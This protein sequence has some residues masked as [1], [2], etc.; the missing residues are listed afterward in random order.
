[1]PDDRFAD[2]EK[3]QKWIAFVRTLNP[4]VDPRAIRLMDQ[5]RRVSHALYQIG[6][7]SVAATGLSY[8]RMRLLMGLLFAEEIEGKACGL[9]PSEISER[10]GTS[11]NTIS[12]LIR[13]LEEEGLVERALDAQD[14]RRF[15]IQLTPAGRRL[16]RNHVSNHLHTMAACIAVL[17]VEEQRALGELLAQL[18]QKAEETREELSRTVT[19]AS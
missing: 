2:E 4:D 18:G 16:V 8:A 10:Q 3:R 9:N 1:M 7:L 19:G 5:M 15:N 13:D 14:R 17:D 12:S 11:R 6:E